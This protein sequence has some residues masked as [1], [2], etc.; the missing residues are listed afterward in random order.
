[1]N[2]ENNYASFEIKRGILFFVYHEDVD[3]NLS[4]AIQI[5]TDRLKLQQGKEFPVLCD[6]RG[7][8]RIDMNARRYLATEGSVFIKALALVSD[9]PLS[10]ILSEIYIKGNTP[11]IPTKI[12][13]NET[14]A[15]TYLS[16]FVS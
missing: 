10:H 14:E 16:E 3:I 11:P 15:L 8:K 12:F 4:V 1:M 5:V 6:T 9:T 2:F 13:N 7:V